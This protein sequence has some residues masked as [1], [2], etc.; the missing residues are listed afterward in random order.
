MEAAAGACKHGNRTS[1]DLEHPEDLTKATLGVLASIWHLQQTRTVASDPAL[2][3]F[4]RFQCAFGADF[5]KSARILTNIGDLA[6]PQVG[7]RSQR[8]VAILDQCCVLRPMVFLQAAIHLGKA[9]D[10]VWVGARN[11]YCQK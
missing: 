11:S 7:P 6:M 1:G 8:S 9:M 4:A 5:S 10:C 2:H 3:F